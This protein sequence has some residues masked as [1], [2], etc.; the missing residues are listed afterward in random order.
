[1]NKFSD[2]SQKFQIFT[3]AQ[4]AVFG[5]TIYEIVL[6][7]I[8]TVIL[9]NLAAYHNLVD[10]CDISG[11]IENQV[12]LLKLFLRAVCDEM[13]EPTCYFLPEKNFK[14]F[15]VGLRESFERVMVGERDLFSGMIQSFTE[16]LIALT[17]F[18]GRKRYSAVKQL[19]RLSMLTI[20]TGIYTDEVP[21]ETLRQLVETMFQFVN[22]KTEKYF[23]NMVENEIMRCLQVRDTNFYFFISSHYYF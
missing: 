20:F 17:K 22:E 1:M 12:S 7:C 21:I 3:S 19:L 14:N 23:F 8:D 2:S 11:F 10:K 4:D 16:L 5:N 13:N 9:Q 15:C 6:C 18:S